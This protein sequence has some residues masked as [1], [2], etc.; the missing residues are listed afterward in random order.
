MKRYLFCLALLCLFASCDRGA[1]P[2]TEYGLQSL[3][4]VSHGMIVLGDRLRDP[5][6]V[7]NMQDAVAALYPTKAREVL[8]ATDLYVRFLP[9]NNDE[10]DRLADLGVEM[11]DHPLD[12][13][14]VR[15]G[16]YYHD[17]E[18]AEDT[19]T[20]QYAVV[21][22]KFQF[23]YG[24][25]YEVIDHCYIPEKDAS[26]RADGI[27][28]E[29]V[30]RESFRR[31]GNGRML[32]PATRGSA[33]AVQP[34]GRITV[35][36]D[37]LGEEVGLKGVKIA[38]NTFVKYAYTYT[39]AEGNYTIPRSYA[40]NIRYRIVFKN[41]RGFGIGVDYL[42]APASASTLG[43]NPA[44]GVNL[45]IDS[46]SDRKL[47]TRSVVNNAAYDYF[48][49]CDSQTQPL[50]APPLNVRFWLFQKL[51]SSSAPMLQH[52]ALVDEDAVAQFLGTYRDLVKLLLP[53]ITL[54]LKNCHDYASVYATACH[55]LAH[56]SHF[57]QAGTGYWNKYIGYVLRCFL[58]GQDA[59][60]DGSLEDA[61]YCEVGEMWAYYLENLVW[62]DRYGEEY[63]AGSWWWFK[64]Q[65]LMR[66]DDRGLNR[67]M[68]FRALTP[69]VCSRVLLAE[70]LAALY[71]DS[72]NLIEQL[73]SEYND[74]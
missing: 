58:A 25:R 6:T 12:F 21:D 39:D 68:I 11:V 63:N 40:S 62:R 72:K 50:T 19:I 3:G 31:T 1:D 38:V 61:G 49:M 73:F 16:D 7:E 5:Y 4:E 23:P 48:A 32:E 22:A 66:L 42:L 56:A 35:M 46:D 29:A 10:Y 59:Y 8:H 54:G 36:D 71:P 30:E 26:T 44:E 9:R 70:K 13:Q 41:V 69:E 64:P 53:D 2:E 24:I 34:S 18:L 60:G 17:P 47:F 20:W 55:E 33:E 27:D 51:G 28:W 65:V 15:E 67:S 57:R 74:E 45:L 52:G 37:R 14:I 43:R